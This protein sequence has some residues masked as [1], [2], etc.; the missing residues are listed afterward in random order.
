MTTPVSEHDKTL[1]AGKRIAIVAESGVEELEL[2]FPHKYFNDRGAV[3]QHLITKPPSSD[4]TKGVIAT[5]TRDTHI[6]TFRALSPGGYFPIGGF[7]EDVNASD[8]DALIIP[9]GYSP[10]NC[11]SNPNVTGFVRASVSA[12]KPVAAICHGP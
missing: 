11:R 6:F 7:I 12:G 8:Y 5:P 4:Y 9:G 2:T 10:D 1:L 3:A